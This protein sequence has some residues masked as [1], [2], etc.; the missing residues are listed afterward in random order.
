M[1][2]TIMTQTTVFL[3][4]ENKGDNLGYLGRRCPFHG[5][6]APHALFSYQAELQGC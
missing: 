2:D 1:L 6:C 5:P 4:E 3:E